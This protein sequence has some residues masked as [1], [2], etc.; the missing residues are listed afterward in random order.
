[1]LGTD[2]SRNGQYQTYRDI[3]GQISLKGTADSTARWIED[4]QLSDRELWA[5]FVEE[6]RVRLDGMDGAWRGE[7][8][9]KMMRGAV[10][11][12]QYT[13]SKRL[14]GILKETVEDMLTA[15]DGLGRISTY[16][17]EKEFFGWDMWCRKYVM[18]GME[19]FLEICTDGELEQRIIKSLCGQCDYLCGKIGDGKIKITDT[20]RIWYG[21]NS[22]SVLE[23]VIRLYR[24]TGN[25]D[26]LKF[27]E[28][29]V[30]SGGASRMNIFELA[31]ENRL[32]PFEYGISKA[33]EMMS[34][35][36]GLLEYYYV[37]GNM[38][39]RIAVENFAKQ[40]AATDI[41]VI[42][43][44]GCTHELFDNSFNRQTLIT[45]E[46][47]P[48]S[49]VMQETCVTVT[50][51]KLCRKLFKLTGD[52]LYA[53][54][55][56]KAFYNAYLGTV[57]FSGYTDMCAKQDISGGRAR[58]T[59]LPFD[60]Y[61]PLTKGIRGI[62]SGGYQILH[63]KTYYGC[64]ACI[65][66]AGAGI[67]VGFAAF[68]TDGGILINGFESGIIKFSTPSGSDAKIEIKGSY[69]YGNEKT[70][71]MLTLKKPETFVIRL[72]SPQNADSMVASVNGTEYKPFCGV[73]GIQREW[74][75]G[76]VIEMSFDLSLHIMKSP[77]YGETE[78]YQINWSTLETFPERKIQTEEEKT[79]VSLRRGPLVLASERALSG[80]I[81]RIVCP[82]D[83][84]RVEGESSDGYRFIAPLMMKNG[85]KVRLCDYAS[86]GR[87]W[88][89]ETEFC[90]W[91]PSDSE[92]LHNL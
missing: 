15:Q 63:D 18:L 20:S 88:N 54:M 55:I 64:C 3:D 65:A 69:P 12:Q 4:R 92:Y 59:F 40:V 17:P 53:D 33:Y 43:T 82:E 48:G 21:M 83:C 27:A 19:F 16:S 91:M 32:A 45:D 66:A 25:N 50:W 74:D 47:N 11:V 84:D 62:K 79:M 24:L 87:T 56:E 41:T 89:S 23:P 68:E 49:K 52:T 85:E 76:D 72:R 67:F 1:M 81:D 78:I 7:Y 13:K 71:I 6:F 58:Y 5:K 46:N 61:S 73:I 22:A 28:H 14:Y 30:L 26:Y 31:Y 42:G 80:D 9:G 44:A 38:K 90:A 39:Y 8:W 75:S 36:E 70:E 2:R 86:A 77:V 57:N 60:S 37:T 29:I 34:C 35:F 51:M 10:L